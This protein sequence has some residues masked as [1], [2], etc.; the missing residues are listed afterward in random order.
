MVIY[1]NSYFS[2]Y[3]HFLIE[4]LLAEWVIMILMFWKKL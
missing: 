3:D 2:K 4:Y 1:Y